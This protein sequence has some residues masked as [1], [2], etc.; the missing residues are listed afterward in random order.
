MFSPVEG[1][2]VKQTPVAQSSPMLPNTIACT[3]TAVPQ[4]GGDVVQAAIGDGARVHP[5]AEHRADRAPEL[6]LRVLRERL[7]GLRCTISL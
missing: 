7:A 6:L 2:R 1:S 4:L 5:A 3:L